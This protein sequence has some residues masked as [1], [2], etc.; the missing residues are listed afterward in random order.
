MRTVKI[1]SR[2]S[3]A[4]SQTANVEQ[5]DG[6]LE[7]PNIKNNVMES[8]SQ[9]CGSGSGIQSLF[10]SWI[11]DPGWVK[12][13]IRI[14]DEHPGSYFREL[15][16]LKALIFFDADPVSGIFLTLDPG[17]GLEKF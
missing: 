3:R 17:S 11:L 13:K 8:K 12:I 4:K 9:C 14:R 15:F 2:A 6:N 5:I 10:N 16:G 7:V 1:E